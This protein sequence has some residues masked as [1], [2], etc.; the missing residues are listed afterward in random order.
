MSYFLTE[1]KIKLKKLNLNHS[2]SDNYFIQLFYILHDIHSHSHDSFA[3][4]DVHDVHEVCI[5]LNN[6]SHVS[7]ESFSISNFNS[8]I[9]STNNGIML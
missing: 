1:C 6:I 9:D 8:L 4:H 5:P 7:L 2:P 3:K